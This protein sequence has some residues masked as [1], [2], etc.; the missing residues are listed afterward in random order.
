LHIH[1]NNGPRREPGYSFSNVRYLKND[2]PL[3]RRP[4]T[5]LSEYNHPWNEI[6]FYSILDVCVY[7]LFHS[8]DRTNKIC[9]IP[10]F[11]ELNSQEL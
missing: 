11:R 1:L 10:I 5:E 4:K 6:F 8:I 7:M 2:R 3:V 9:Y